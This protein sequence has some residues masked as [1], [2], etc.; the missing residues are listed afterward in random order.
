M[1]TSLFFDWVLRQHSTTSCIY[2]IW[3]YYLFACL[4]EVQNFYIFHVWDK[5][6]SLWTNF[7]STCIQLFKH[8]LS[9]SRT[10]HCASDKYLQSS[11]ETKTFEWK[12][13]DDSFRQ[14]NFSSLAWDRYWTIFLFRNKAEL[15]S[16]MIFRG[17]W[18]TS[19]LKHLY[20]SFYFP[21][22]SK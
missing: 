11:S 2:F 18:I 20:Y 16:K 5:F 19:S 1:L 4:T 6:N 10:G 8:R 9:S 22:K 12:I 3:A 14:V 21:L 7:V 15:P 17:W 13:P